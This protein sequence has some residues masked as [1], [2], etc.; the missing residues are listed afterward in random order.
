MVIFIQVFVIIFILCKVKT[1]HNMFIIIDLQLQLSS[2][3]ITHIAEFTQ[4]QVTQDFMTFLTGM[5]GKKAFQIFTP[6]KP[7]LHFMFNY[8][9]RLK[10]LLQIS[11]LR[12]E[13]ILLITGSLVLISL[14][15]MPV[16]Y[17]DMRPV[18]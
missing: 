18:I 4:N 8:S 5:Y 3:S 7:N 6:T 14:R 13:P 10:I 16:V 11:P 17:N 15:I 9:L 2:G 1:N 12:H